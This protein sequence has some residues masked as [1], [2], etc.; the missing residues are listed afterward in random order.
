MQRL[1]QLASATLLC[2]TVAAC[3]STPPPPSGGVRVAS[4]ADKPARLPD[5]PRSYAE[6]WGSNERSS[7]TSKPAKPRGAN[8]PGVYKVGPP[9]QVGGVWYVPAEQPDYEET[10]LASWYG[11]NFH[12]RQTANGETF[13]SASFTAAHTTLPIPS[14]VEVTNLENGRTLK[15]RVNDRGPFSPARIIDLSQAAADELGFRTKGTASVRVRYLG[16]ADGMTVAAREPARRAA[17]QVASVTSSPDGGWAVQAGAFAQ[18]DRA[19]HVARVLKTAGR[20]Q[21]KPLDRNGRTLYRVVVGPWSDPGAAAAA[22]SEVAALGFT[23][24]KVVAAF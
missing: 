24:A 9:Y 13:D 20:T 16:R 21:I 18:P 1:T 12:G 3:A 14:L 23:D 2:A 11:A 19:D 15:V 8:T 6:A 17:L 10:G 5:R 4:R 7:P 22:R